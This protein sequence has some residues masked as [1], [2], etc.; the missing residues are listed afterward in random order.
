MK[1]W[2]VFGALTMVFAL[3]SWGKN[4][5]EAAKTVDSPKVVVEKFFAAVG[6]FDFDKAATYTLPEG[7]IKNDIERMKKFF[8]DVSQEEKDS[9]SKM[10]K[11]SMKESKVISEKVDGDK[12][13]VDYE[14]E[15]KGKRYFKL[16]LK[17]GEWKI[18]DEGRY[19]NEK[20][21][22]K[23]AELDPKAEA[24]AKR[25]A[26]AE[27]IKRAAEAEEIKRAVEAA[28]AASK[29]AEA[30]TKAAEAAQ[31]AAE[32]AQ[33]VAEAAPK[34]AFKAGSKAATESEDAL[35]KMSADI[36]KELKNIN[37]GNN[38]SKAGKEGNA[39]KTAEASKDGNAAK[40]VDSPKVVVEK[41]FA[42]VGE[43]DFDKASAYILP[44]GKM[45]D[46]IEEMKQGLKD[47]SQKEKDMLSKMMKEI[48][49]ISEKVD[50]D[51]ATVEFENEGKGKMSLALKLKNGEWKIDG[52][53]EAREK[54]AEIR[55]I[56]HIK[57]VML[58][59]TMY[60][61]DNNDS[62][63]PAKDWDKAILKELSGAE[64]EKCPVDGRLYRYLG[65]G[66]IVAKVKD[67]FN[68][69]LVICENDHKGK[70]VVGFLDGHVASFDSKTV[71][72]AIKAAKP[73]KLPVLK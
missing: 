4:A 5:G 7:K 15:G 65:N 21:E 11:E 49:V 25:A 43:F 72:D 40:T 10:M 13:I 61:I 28:V 56:N 16:E 68:T 29:A 9:L 19:P 36:E 69:V 59:I 58:A 55:C 54:A 14:N 17:D 1:K 20:L 46:I 33:K 23:L 63:P 48:K 18:A 52:V 73:G 70:T 35:K 62:L 71:Q 22:K 27:A 41:F 38:S 6:E 30:A 3:S 2:F 66:Q 39:A 34:A 37:C 53:G 31:K 67:P 57:Q 8:K 24:I 47:A 26:E 12:A 32:A 44:E 42:A 45:K 51:N 50:G 64:D 60:Y